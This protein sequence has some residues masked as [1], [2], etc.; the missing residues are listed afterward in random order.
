MREQIRRLKWFI[1]GAGQ[2]FAPQLTLAILARRSWVH[3]PEIVLLPHLADANTTAIDAGANKGVYTHHLRRRHA[4]VI[5]F[6]PLP[7]LARALARAAPSAEVHAVALSDKH[8]TARLT[9]PVGFNELGTIE[10][11][12]KAKPGQAVPLEEHDVVVKPLDSFKFKNVG[13]LKIDVEGHEH[14]V[15]EGA[16]ALIASSKP[17]VIIEV[18]ERHKIGAVDQVRSYF[19]DQDYEGFFLDGHRFRSLRDFALERDQPKAAIVDAVKTDRYINNF[20][21]IHRARAQERSV[22]INR[23]LAE[24]RVEREQ[25]AQPGWRHSLARLTAMAGLSARRS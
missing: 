15:L 23:W 19:A 4:R 25:R 18:E 7:Q 6:E 21:F 20:I 16:R 3:E 1:R 14:A 11:T 24:T 8:G 5:A 22:A 10:A 13:L 2:R 9:L 17:T 12:A